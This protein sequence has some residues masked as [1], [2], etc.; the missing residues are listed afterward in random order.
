MNV[1]MALL[2][3]GAVG[4]WDASKVPS[5]PELAAM[6]CCS[7]DDYVARQKQVEPSD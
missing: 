5:G 4:T 3:E 7:G 1:A 2:R 6:A